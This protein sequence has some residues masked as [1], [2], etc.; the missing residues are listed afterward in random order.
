LLDLFNKHGVALVSISETLDS[1]S[2]A[3]RL[4]VSMLGVVAQWEREAIGERTATALQHKR[5]NLVAYG[6]T[7]FGYRRSGSQLV[8]HDGEQNVLS[9]ALRMDR[10]GH[11]F[12]AIGAMLSERC[13]R[14]FG[15]S[16]V[17]ALLRSRIVTEAMA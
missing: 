6:K 16:T 17:R 3:G 7:P 14:A 1:S 11:S 8:P 15:P 13:G 2:A 10:E 9:D 5:K 4:V 12:R